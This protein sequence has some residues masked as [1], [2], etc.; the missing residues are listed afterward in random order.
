MGKI[1]YHLPLS[2]RRN[3]LFRVLP[4]DFDIDAKKIRNK[5]QKGKWLRQEYKNEPFGG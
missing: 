5:D 2:E 3:I 4:K 1:T